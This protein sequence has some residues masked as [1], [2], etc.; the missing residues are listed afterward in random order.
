MN[1]NIAR[2]SA[3]TKRKKNAPKKTKN[4]R[5]II[6]GVCAAAVITVVVLVVLITGGQGNTEAFSGGGQIVQLLDDERF[7]AS[8]AHGARK[9]GTYT[10]TTDGDRI[11]VEFISNG[12]VE[13]GWIEGDVLTLPVEWEDQ[14]G[15]G[16]WLTRK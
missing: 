10:K 15:H 13:I 6:I 11:I 5:L 8:L 3:N 12:R 9:S 2:S 4:K 16:R 14:C 1:T 7:L